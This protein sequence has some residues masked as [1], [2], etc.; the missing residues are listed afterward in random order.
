[1]TFDVIVKFETGRKSALSPVSKPG[2]F[3]S[4]TTLLHAS[5][6]P[7]DGRVSPCWWWT[8]AG[9]DELTDDE[10]RYRV[11]RARLHRRRHDDGARRAG[12]V[13]TTRTT[14][15][16]FCWQVT[17]V[18]QLWPSWP[19]WSTRPS[20]PRTRRR[21]PVTSMSVVHCESSQGGE[22]PNCSSQHSAQRRPSS[23]RG[24]V[25]DSDVPTDQLTIVVLSWRVRPHSA[26]VSLRTISPRR[27]DTTA[28][29]HTTS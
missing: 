20:R 25:V 7:V 14:S 2:F 23:A 26:A 10:G 12:S 1:M 27:R 21:C 16:W 3:N 15:W 11:Q 18:V 4:L 8:A 19:C 5:V 9:V 29:V 28:A 6:S 22:R 17:G 13:G 24:A